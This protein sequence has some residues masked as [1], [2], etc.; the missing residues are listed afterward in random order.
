M[1]PLPALEAE[2]S[3]THGKILALQKIMDGS[4]PSEIGHLAESVKKYTREE[5]KAKAALDEARAALHSPLI[6]TADIQSAIT[7]MQTLPEPE[8]SLISWAAPLRS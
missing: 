5:T 1:D 7:Q 4:E 3:K 8:K 2:L 6:N